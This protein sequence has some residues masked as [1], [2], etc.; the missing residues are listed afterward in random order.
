MSSRYV[1]T[2]DTYLQEHLTWMRERQYAEGHVEHRKATVGAFLAWCEGRNLRYAQDITRPVVERYQ[3]HLHHHRKKNGKPLAAFTQYSALC[4]IKMFFKWLAKQRVVLNNPASELDMPRLPVRLPRQVL[5]A[6]EA[7]Q[8][9]IQPDLTTLTGQRDRAMLEVF[10]STGLRRMELA[11]L[12][13]TDLDVERGILLVREGK[14]KRD[15]MV[16]VGTRALEWTEKY[17]ND[18]RPKLCDEVD[19]GT[20][21]LSSTG[22]GFH[23]DYLTRLTRFYVDQAKIGK[24]G[25]CHLFRHTMATVMLDNGADI[26]FIQAMLG[27]ANLDTTAVYT[28]VAIGKLKEVHE[29]TH[30]ANQSSTTRRTAEPDRSRLVEE[31][32]DALDAEDDDATMD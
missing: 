6:V 23:P 26:R 31:M 11:R 4:S 15:R 24:T 7:E 30:P 1:S 17:L 22:M 12:A 5:T 29:R 21:F 9:L 27:H 32:L 3:T 14:W 13:V 2:L 18:V 8:V 10:Y 28:R 19:D 20:L 16:P 25:S